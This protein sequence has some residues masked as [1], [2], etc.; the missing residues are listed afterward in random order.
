[1]KGGG[2]STVNSIN[3]RYLIIS[4]LV[5]ICVSVSRD[6]LGKSEKI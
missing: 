4:A 2:D 3:S 5:G 1:M 6:Q